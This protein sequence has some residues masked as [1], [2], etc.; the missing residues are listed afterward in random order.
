MAGSLAQHDTKQA[1]I[2]CDSVIAK[3]EQYKSN[4]NEYPGSIMT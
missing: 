4:Y 3:I 2:F 1:K